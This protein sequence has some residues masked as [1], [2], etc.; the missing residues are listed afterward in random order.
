MYTTRK[1]FQDTL[2]FKYWHVGYVGH[3]LVYKNVNLK[4]MTFETFSVLTTLL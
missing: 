2:S 3:V 4:N 1:F